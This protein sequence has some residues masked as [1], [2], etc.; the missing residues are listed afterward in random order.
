MKAT[1]SIDWYLKSI[2]RVPL[3]TA[4]QEIT[5]GKTISEWMELRE[6]GVEASAFTLDQKRLNR[7]GRRAYDQMYSANLRLVVNVAKKYARITNQLELMDLV[8]EGNCG[9]ARAVEKFDFSRGYK[10][11]TYA[12]WWIRQAITRAI[13][14]TDSTV[15]MP[16]HMHEKLSKVR[17]FSR[18]F[19]ASYG[20]LPSASEISEEFDIDSAYLDQLNAMAAG[21]ISLHS[22]ANNKDPDASM[23]IDVIPADQGEEEEFDFLQ[24][25]RIWDLKPIVEKQLPE[26]SA[27]VVQLA[28]FSDKPMTLTEIGKKVG[29]SRECVRQTTIRA[30]ALF[31]NKYALMYGRRKVAA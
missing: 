22:K 4:A 7:R 9:L 17:T 8:Q 13:S 30:E 26:H 1:D 15:R 16:I 18:D 31:R 23:L 11:S 2:A 14:Q 29:M 28:F 3:L 5:L 10:F 25:E 19:L 27:E 24:K 6:S 20:R 21:C 12:Y